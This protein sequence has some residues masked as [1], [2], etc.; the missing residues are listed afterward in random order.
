MFNRGVERIGSHASDKE[1]IQIEKRCE[2]T[3]IRPS[4]GVHCE[5]R[6]AP[7]IGLRAAFRRNDLCHFLN[8]GTSESQTH[9]PMGIGISVWGRPHLNNQF[10][11]MFQNKILG[12]TG[13]VY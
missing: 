10:E 3:V 9:D 8:R 4:A 7:T 6:S 12:D 1:R 11:E 5:Q 13:A 2:K